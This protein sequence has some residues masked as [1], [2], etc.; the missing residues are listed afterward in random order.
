MKIVVG[1]G[2][3]GKEYEGTRHNIGFEVLDI[4]LDRFNT[5]FSKKSKFYG[6]AAE[7]KVSEEKVVLLKPRTFMN[8]SGKAVYAVLSWYGCKASDLIV[9]LDDA[10]ISVGNI[11]VR[12]KG[13]SA[14]HNGLKSIID[15]LGTQ[16]FPR[17]RVGIGSSSDMVNHVLDR[18]SRKTKAAVHEAI[19]DAADAVEIII[20]K[21]VETAMDKFNTK[22]DN[23]QGGAS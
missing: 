22:E 17:V 5:Q 9:T 20:K 19:T 16:D 10:S 11:R 12:Q 2:N 3:P 13:S 18:F 23:I 21:S 6:E 8:N 1:L 14:G 7:A 15:C 4:L